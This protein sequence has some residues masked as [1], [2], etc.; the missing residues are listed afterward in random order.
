MKQTKHEK[1]VFDDLSSNRSKYGDHLDIDTW[2]KEW[3]GDT[4]KD[5]SI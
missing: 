4:L 1:K 5:L 3:R 2:T